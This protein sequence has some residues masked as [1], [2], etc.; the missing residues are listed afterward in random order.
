MHAVLSN[1]EHSRVMGQQCNY[2]HKGPHIMVDARTDIHTL[3]RR[4]AEQSLSLSNP[5]AGTC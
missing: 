1:H 3:K 4:C 2:K 5:V